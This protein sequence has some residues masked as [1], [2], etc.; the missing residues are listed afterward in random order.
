MFYVRWPRS[1]MSRHTL[2]CKRPASLYGNLR[3]LANVAICVRHVQ[4]MN[5][6]YSLNISVSRLFSSGY[7]VAK[8]TKY[9]Q[10]K[11]D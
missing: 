5:K 4:S 7:D 8:I 6:L 1:E 11:S 10:I 3:A 9:Y 2:S